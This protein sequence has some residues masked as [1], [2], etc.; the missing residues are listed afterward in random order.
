[1]KRLVSRLS[2]IN[3][4]VIFTSSQPVNCEDPAIQHF[5]FRPE[6]GLNTHVHFINDPR[7]DISR[8]ILKKFGDG[9]VRIDQVDSV[10]GGSV[11][12]PCGMVQPGVVCVHDLFGDNETLVDFY[13]Y[14]SRGSG[15]IVGG[16]DRLPACSKLR[17]I[18]NR[19][20][21]LERL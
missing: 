11:E 12:F 3:G 9:V 5:R 14:D 19:V 10:V 21:A 18:E 17:L 6:R 7:N 20:R 1:M 15:G 2:A 4:K 16:D 13:A 8:S